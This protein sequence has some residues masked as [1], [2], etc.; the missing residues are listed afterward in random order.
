MSDSI[1]ER[2]AIYLATTF[3]LRGAEDCTTTPFP[4]AARDIVQYFIA[5]SRADLARQILAMIPQLRWLTRELER[6]MGKLVSE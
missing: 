4:E 5:P 1:E 2:I 3:G 6:E